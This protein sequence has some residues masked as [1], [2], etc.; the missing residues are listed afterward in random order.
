[1]PEQYFDSLAGRD[2]TDNIRAAIADYTK[3][4]EGNIAA[5]QA[6]KEMSAQSRMEAKREQRNA[7]RVAVSGRLQKEAIIFGA[8]GPLEVQW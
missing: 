3:R 8:D 4:V 7:Y 6:F 5:E 2:R 1:M